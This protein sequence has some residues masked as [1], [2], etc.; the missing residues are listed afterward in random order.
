[1]A[2]LYREA[3]NQHRSLAQDRLGQLHPV[4][5]GAPLDAV[6]GLRLLLM[7]AVA[8]SEGPSSMILPWRRY[9]AGMTCVSGFAGGVG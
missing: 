6:D 1:V 5:N 2:R 9:R 3:A 8:R 7:T 4:A